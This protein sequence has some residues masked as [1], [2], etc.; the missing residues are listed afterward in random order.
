MIKRAS[1]ILLTLFLLLTS[2][3]SA[4]AASYIPNVVVAETSFESNSGSYPC[5][6][7]EIKC[8]NPSNESY[9]SNLQYV[10]ANPPSQNGTYTINGGTLICKHDKTGDKEIL[11]SGNFSGLV[12]E[13]GY[14]N[15]KI[16]IKLASGGDYEVRCKTKY[17]GG[18][19]EANK[20]PGQTIETYA[21]A[22]GGS[23][24]FSLFLNWINRGEVKIESVKIEGY[25][26]KKVIS[27]ESPAVCSGKETTLSALGATGTS[28]Q[29]YVSDN[30]VNYTPIPGA[31]QSTYKVVVSEKKYY[32]LNDVDGLMVY[33]VLC[34]SDNS[35]STNPVSERFQMN[36][37]SKAF[38]ALSSDQID[39]AYTHASS[40]PI[41]DGEYAIVHKAVDGGWWDDSPIV[42]R[43]LDSDSKD[44]FLL[45]NCSKNDHGKAMYKRRFDR[46][47]SNTLYKFSAAVS[48]LSMVNGDLGIDV[49]FDVIAIGGSNNN[50][51]LLP[52]PISVT[53]PS[54]S[55]T[56]IEKNISFV[57]KEC[58]SV[59]VRL[60][61][62]VKN[63]DATGGND[64]GIDDIV[65]GVC[66]PEIA[67]YS[68]EAWS[69]KDREV[70]PDEEP[71]TY[72]HVG[73]AMNLDE[74]LPND[75]WYYF[76]YK[77]GSTWKPVAGTNPTQE[78]KIK[79][80]I[81]EATHS[82]GVLYR[83]WIA[84]DKNTVVD[85]AQGKIVA[86]SCQ[87]FAQ[88]DAISITYKCAVPSVESNAPEMNNYLECPTTANTIDL[89]TLIKKVTLVDGTAVNLNNIAASGTLKWY[90]A[91]DVE[92]TNTVVN[93]P[94]QGQTNTYKVSFTQKDDA[95]SKY[96]E[97]K[98]TTFTVGIKETIE[99]V[100]DPTKFAGCLSEI[101]T[102]PAGRSYYVIDGTDEPSLY[103]F[104]YTWVK[105]NPD[106]SE[107]P[108]PLKTG[109][110]KH[111][112]L[113]LEAGSGFINLYVTSD[114]KAFCDSKPTKLEYS[115]SDNPNFEI[116]SVIV[117]CKD[118]ILTEGIQ[119]KIK[120]M[121]G[122]DKLRITRHATDGISEEMTSF[123]SYED[124][125]P[126][127][128]KVITYNGESEYTF[129]DKYFDQ[130][131]FSRPQEF[132]WDTFE[133]VRYIVTFGDEESTCTKMTGTEKYSISSTNKFTFTLSDN[134]KDTSK[135]PDIQE[136]HVCE[137]EEVKVKAGYEL[138]AGEHFEW[139]VNGE[140]P[141]DAD[142]DSQSYT[143]SEIEETTTFKATIIADEG[144]ESCGGSAEITI[145]VD[146]KPEIAV[147]DTSLCA[148]ESV[149]IKVTGEGDKYAW[150]PA[151]YLSDATAKTPKIT[152]EATTK[153]SLDVTK[154]LCTVTV[155][156][157]DVVVNPLPEIGNISVDT[158]QE[159]QNTL[160]VEID[161]VNAYSYSL[162]GITYGDKGVLPTTLPIG[163][164]QLYVIDEHGCKSSKLFE[165]EPTP[166]YPEKYF[167]PNDD[168]VNETWN[169][170]NLNMYPAYIV[171]I[172]DRYGKRLF[173]Q[174]VGSFNT[175][176]N[177]VD[178]DEF[179]GWDGM[180]NGHPMP[181]DDYWYL[182][183]VEEIRKQYTGHFT[184]KR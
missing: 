141:A 158:N 48:S 50:Q 174:R 107:D 173:V 140:T 40:S 138:K 175:G 21:T 144:V 67:L 108:T 137:K 57:T 19:Y 27:S 166:I 121:S 115:I 62:N 154:G 99:V 124:I 9:N 94:A 93:F 41:D 162:D 177:T 146:K 36:T 150:T 1:T 53:A 163:Y 176:G 61:N 101:N 142:A 184:L 52:E 155:E 139:K 65:F 114:S 160:K 122:T 81:E 136:F 32:K 42:A 130:Q 38:E 128:H 75:K 29:W 110:D 64:V 153:Y 10:T 74:I 105:I 8:L 31:T 83:A 25:S 100:V 60:Y 69:A 18:N 68:D 73:S 102:D 85:A 76:E 161:D 165:V 37:P 134:I 171:E 28:Y 103:D 129:V 84:G 6:L 179:T 87:S 109:K 112:A 172:F 98:K 125:D 12:S 34:C 47:C 2:A 33:P 145:Y 182:I 143:I 149:V 20:G 30:G 147:R 3:T 178:G 72:I 23:I 116:E 118:K 63:P 97:S 78:D 131:Y 46:L 151:T 71:N 17:N 92:I 7:S 104:T 117:P 80:S 88:S 180:Y 45:V 58:S 5:K 156:D 35:A 54:L 169:I 90:D 95:T 14:N 43:S 22:T 123:I 56:W 26:E 168:G 51:S 159:G 70:C 148:G 181:S 39:N 15:Y 49:K 157:I 113:P 55:T 77:D 167:T 13:S 66:T 152:P 120:N 11:L 135:N 91:N 82:N 4:W 59:E 119:L 132:E 183:T 16:T 111:Y 127:W 86:G 170:E 126:R 164:N 44:G 106:G 89:K 79:V 96:R 24:S 133:S